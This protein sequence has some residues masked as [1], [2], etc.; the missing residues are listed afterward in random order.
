[1]PVA[2]SWNIF[3]DSKEFKSVLRIYKKKPKYRTALEIIK[4]DENRRK[5][6]ENAEIGNKEAL[7]SEVYDKQFWGSSK[8]YNEAKESDFN[9]FIDGVA[10]KIIDIEI[11]EVDIKNFQDINFEVEEKLLAGCGS[12]II[13]FKLCKEDVVEVIDAFRREK[14]LKSQLPEL[15]KKHH[16]ESSVES[17]KSIAS[18]SHC[19]K[20]QRVP[21]PENTKKKDEKGTKK[22]KM[23][24]LVDALFK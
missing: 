4:I 17:N 7:K 11:N 6:I 22:G 12:G 23:Q 13:K 24:K 1:M 14:L 19:G 18:S 20:K 2:I 10:Q 21:S 8:W 9:K 15:R 3:I 5:V 16:I